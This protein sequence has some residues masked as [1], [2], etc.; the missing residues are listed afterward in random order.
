MSSRNS[1]PPDAGAVSPLVRAALM[2]RNLE[3]SRCFYAGGLGLEEEHL[4]LTDFSR[5]P[6]A[7]LLHLPAGTPFRGMILK[8]RGPNF[9][10]IGL[11]ELGLPE[12]STAPGATSPVR[13]GESILV[14]YVVDLDST[15]ARLEALGGRR[16]GDPTTFHLPDASFAPAKEVILR[17]PDGFAVNLIET[18]PATAFDCDPVS[19]R[20]RSRATD[21]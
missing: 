13:C 3:R 15:L 17:D 9:G 18:S 12:R 2:V 1:S 11:F 7:G 5:S 4:E 21:A 16:L 8:A 10:M 19:F 6:A 14:F 20:S